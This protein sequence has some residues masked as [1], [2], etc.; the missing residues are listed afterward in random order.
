ME[1]VPATSEAKP[2]PP[3]A[4]HIPRAK[5]VAGLGTIAFSGPGMSKQS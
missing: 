4:W 1:A 5:C 2:M 3:P